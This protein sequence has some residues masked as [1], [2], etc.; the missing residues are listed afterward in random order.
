MKL[1]SNI[2]FIYCL[3]IALFGSKCYFLFMLYVLI[4]SI[5]FL[6]CI[7][8]H[9]KCHLRNGNMNNVYSENSERVEKSLITISLRITPSMNQR[10]NREYFD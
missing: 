1:N 8:T 6:K 10:Q 7:T 4:V 3:N 5:V 9:T 2:D